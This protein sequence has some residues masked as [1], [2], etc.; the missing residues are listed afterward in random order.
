M[1]VRLGP[2]ASEAERCEYQAAEP[3]LLCQRVEDNA[4]HLALQKLDRLLGFREKRWGSRKLSTLTNTRHG[5]KAAKRLE[6]K[7]K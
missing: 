2:M 5:G 3:Q 1:P 7:Q 6:I 4:F